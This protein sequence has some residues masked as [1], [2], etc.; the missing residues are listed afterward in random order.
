MTAVAALLLPV[1]ALLSQTPSPSPAGPPPGCV[2][3]EARQFDFWAGEWDVYVGGKLA[4]RNVIA[5][6]HNGCALVESW[7][8]AGGGTGTSVNF[9]DPGRKR[10]H[11]TWAG[12]G[13]SF[14]YLDGGWDGRQMI[15]EGDSRQA[16]GTV[17][18]NR[19]SWTPLAGGG[20]R[21]RWETSPDGKAWTNVFD[22]A[23]VA[24]GS[25]PP[26]PASGR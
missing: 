24:K 20:L 4:G 8:G 12:S 7:T 5:K 2:S 25:A 6:K 13:A 21:Q 23:Y 15:L 16:D 9:Y 22:G 17:L 1:A 26:G 10:W 19:I 3:A 18:K 11:Q 14:L